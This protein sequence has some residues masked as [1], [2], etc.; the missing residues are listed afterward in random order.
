MDEFFGIPLPVYCEGGN[1]LEFLAE[2]LNATS[3][4]AF[5]LVGFGIYK[6]LIKHRIQKVEYRVVLI[7][8]FLIGF[9]SFFWHTTRNSFTLLLDA[10]PSALSFT[11]ITYIFLSK[12]I[13]NKAFAFLIAGLLLPSRFFISSIAPTDTISSLIRNSVNA[14]VFLVIIAWSFKKYGRIAFEG[15]VVLSV[16][17]T[18]IIMRGIDLQVCQTFPLGT[19]FLWHIMN[20][21]AVYLAV[22]FLI[23]LEYTF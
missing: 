12:L 19:H 9:G 3:N 15:L 23:K 18:A 6:L 5:I 7:L 14:T 20:A 1:F 21:L 16:Y 8:I 2:P 13:K 22:K 10:I 11:L 17:L 4:V